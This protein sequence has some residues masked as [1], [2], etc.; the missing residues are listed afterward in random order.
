[1]SELTIRILYV[2]DNQA[3]FLLIKELLLDIK[4]T[5]YDVTW[6]QTYE[7]G[8]L[9]IDK[10]LSN[11]CYD[12]VLIDYRIGIRTGVD[13]IVEQS[14]RNT[15]LPMILITGYDDIQIDKNAMHSGAADFI[16]KNEMSATLLERTIRYN[17]ERKIEKSKFREAI[18][19]AE[20]AT[21]LK[22]KF[23]SLVVHDIRSPMA[24]TI[25]GILYVAVS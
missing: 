19:K 15:H 9:H 25:S 11:N 16:S 17:I 18:E 4:D 5:K 23:V 7:K 24:T 1:M 21:K 8:V 2:E 3:D 20:N 10:H 6:A 13:F 22:D 14:E 12:I